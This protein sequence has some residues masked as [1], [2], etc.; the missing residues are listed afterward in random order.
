MVSVRDPC[1]PKGANIN[2]L[3][4]NDEKNAFPE[5]SNKKS[6]VVILTSDKINF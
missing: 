2:R 6:W 5:N 3:K 1:R 4:W